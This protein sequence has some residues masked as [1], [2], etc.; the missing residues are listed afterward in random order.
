MD[1]PKRQQKTPD[2]A[3]I[4]LRSDGQFSKAETGSQ[5]RIGHV[6]LVPLAEE[7]DKPSEDRIVLLSDGIF[8][9][10]LTLLVLGIQIP[11]ADAQSRDAF[12]K[13]LTGDFLSNTL[14]YA[15]TFLVL[16]SYWLDHRRLM[17]SIKQID[18][19]FL[20]LNLIFLAFVA[21][22]PVVTNIVQYKYPEA[23][24]VYTA[25]LVGCG[26]SLALLWIYSLYNHR[27]MAVRDL[28]GR[29]FHLI[30]VV[31]HPTFLLAS[32]CLLFIPNFPPNHVFYSWLL[33]PFM[34]NTARIFAKLQRGKRAK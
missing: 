25:V 29:N 18:R 11:Q 13:V 4:S 15:L 28:S 34:E 10:A 23:V 6:R 14:F 7:T 27:L 22:F 19:I 2:I 9:I 1:V 20:R 31:L 5:A 21:F 26:Y 33:L 17:K 32:L 3:E 8:A 16:A 12:I 24:I 30:E